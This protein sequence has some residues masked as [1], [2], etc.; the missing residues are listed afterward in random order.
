MNPKW[1]PIT[2]DGKIDRLVEESGE[3]VEVI[4][5]VLRA[6]GK[7]SRFGL[8]SAHPEGGPNNA[9]LM[10]SEMADLR[11]A[12]SAVE[13]GITEHAKVKV[14]STELVWTSELIS[15]KDLRELL[16][17]EDMSDDQFN[18][19][20]KVIGVCAGQWHREGLDWRLYKD[21]EWDDA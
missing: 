8:D 17:D 12:I 13:N 20:H 6:V 10:L 2:L 1:L 14:G 19:E 18:A 16:G 15:T 9:A 4:G 5:R 11:H 21:P 7:T 3:V